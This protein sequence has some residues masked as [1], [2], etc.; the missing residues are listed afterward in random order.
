METF[1]EAAIWNM[2]LNLFFKYTVYF[3]TILFC[4]ILFYFYTI[5]AFS[6]LKN[7]LL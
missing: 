2:Y 6:T 7:I 3:L 4:F 5:Y 1:V